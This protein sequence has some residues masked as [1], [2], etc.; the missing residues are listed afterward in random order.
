M[1]VVV[2]CQIEDEDNWVNVDS[3]KLHKP[4][5]Q[6]SHW[7]TFSRSQ[8]CREFFKTLNYTE[9]LGSGI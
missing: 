9:S 2:C 8:V 7:W 6:L 4:Q 1:V 5:R 3:P